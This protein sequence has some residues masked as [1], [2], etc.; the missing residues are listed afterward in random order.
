M[1]Q[2]TAA[3]RWLVA[4]ELQQGQQR[5]PMVGWGLLESASFGEAF[6]AE[7]CADREN[8]DNRVAG[9]DLVA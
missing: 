7:G 9:T 5:L 3:V 1:A 4:C 8:A 2:G 6:G